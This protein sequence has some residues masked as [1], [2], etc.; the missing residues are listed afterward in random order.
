MKDL[1]VLIPTGIIMAVAGSIYVRMQ[2]HKAD[3]KSRRAS[4][5][6]KSLA[7]AMTIIIALYYAIFEGNMLAYVF[8]LAFLLCSAADTL[9]E[10]AFLKGVLCFGVAQV[11]FSIGYI[12]SYGF[13]IQSLL[14]FLVLYGIIFM[15]FR[16]DIKSIEGGV[17]LVIYVGFLTFAFAQAAAAFIAAPSYLR[18]FAM[19]G[20]LLF[21]IS[22]C[23]IGLN[24]TKSEHSES[25]L[26]SIAVMST[27]YLALYFIALSLR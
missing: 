9:L 15:V 14:I 5:I 12:L 10:L 25:E 18:F 13:H 7:S 2:H 11:C 20:S 1:I 17:Q 26:S 4:L 8:A 21:L 27:Y 3:E 6:Y 19:T 16:K 24:K 22:D 23:L